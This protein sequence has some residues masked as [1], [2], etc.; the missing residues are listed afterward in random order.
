MQK[1]L[2]FL[3]KYALPGIVLLFLAFIPLYPKIPLFDIF[4]TWVYIRLEDFLIFIACLLFGFLLFK[5]KVSLKTP[6][7]LPIMVFWITGFVSLL[8]ALL[9][10]FP[11]LSNVFPHVAVLHY[12]RHIEYMV[13]FFLS[14][15]VIANNRKLLPFVIAVLA[16]TSAAVIA[17]GLGQKYNGWPAFSTM[18]E[19]FAKGV[20]LRLPPTA[21]IMSTFAGHYDLAAYLVMT[22][23]IFGSL[24]FGVKKWF[25]RVGFILL[26]IASFIL[27]LLTASRVSFGVYLLTVSVM[28]WW[29]KKRLLI[30]PVIIASVIMVNFVSGASDRFLKTLRFN[31]VV[32]D[33]STGK[34]IGTLEKVEGGTATLERIS[35]PDEENLPK[36]S[37]FINVPSSGTATG[38]A[39]IGMV[40][41][42]KKKDLTAGKGDVA[43]VSGS[44]LIQKA[45]VLDISITTRFQGQWPRAIEAFKRNILTG[46]GYSTLNLAADGNYHR[47]LGE[48]GIL[49]T[50][51][52]LGIFL[53]AFLW[54]WKKRALLEP[55]EKAFVTGLFAGIVGLAANAVLIDVFAA[56]KVAYPLWL[57]LGIAMA[58]LAKHELHISY[59]RFMYSFFTHRLMILFY[60]GVGI[61]L[62][63]GPIINSYFTGDDFTWLRW[64]AE[65]TLTTIPQYFTDAQGFFYRPIPKLWYFSLFSLFWLV[66]QAYHIASIVL[67]FG[68]SL[69][70]LRLMLQFRMHKIIAIVSTILFAVFSIHHENIMWI[71]GQSSLLAVFFFLLALNVLISSAHNLKNTNHKGEILSGVLILLSMFS[72][73]SLIVAPLIVAIMNFFLFKKKTY[74]WML[75]L[76]PIVLIARTMSGAVN[77]SGDYGYNMSKLLVNGIGNGL[78]YITAILFGPQAIE[79]AFRIRELLR[80]YALVLSVG[81]LIM[82]VISVYALIKHRAYL[83]KESL[84]VVLVACFFVSL[85]PFLGLGAASDRYALLPS[86][87]LVMFIAFVAQKVW[88]SRLPISL[89]LIPVVIVCGLIVINYQDTQKLIKEWQFA[90]NTTEKALLSIRTGF[91]PPTNIKTFVF[92][93]VPI[94]QGRAW[95]FPTGLNDALWHMFRQTPYYVTQVQTIDQAFEYPHPKDTDKVILQF[96]DFTLKQVVKEPGL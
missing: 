12:I 50:I 66:P 63:F 54:F 3:S 10:I 74:Y 78:T 59:A 27:L 57:L 42:I 17:Y 29:Q 24:I 31:D 53:Y 2:Q 32:V 58:I 82:M 18:N 23:P 14:Y 87:F 52:F 45:F 73:E 16:V 55:L 84:L 47:L 5:K 13:L 62:L 83:M 80:S 67:F 77:P 30:I 91:F 43:T 40:E 96:E 51:S 46:S 92:I 7:T 86:V 61:F 85:V 36:G 19:E 60:A 48:T 88:A 35:E 8:I 90:G 65:S 38:S 75:I 28:L 21:R 25:L 34:P 72:W 68:I 41:F 70:V 64:A 49:G 39:D 93:D 1:L 76:I 44:F 11:H 22:I 6:L 37:G 15:A 20:P 79:Q 26:W 56:S 4:G 33:L 95:I 81:A 94:R 71:S 9:F 69:L 89:R